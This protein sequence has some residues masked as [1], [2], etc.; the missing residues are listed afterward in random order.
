MSIQV[1]NERTFTLH[2]AHTTYQFEA[3]AFGIVRHL[4]YGSRVED[5]DFSYLVQTRAR[6]FSGNPADAGAD[7]TISWDTLP[8]EYPATGCGD[9]RES[10]IVA[11]HENGSRALDLRYHSYRILDGKPALNGLPAS[12][13]GD[14]TQ[15]LEIT[16]FDRVSKLRVY[17]LYSVFEVRDVITRSVRVEN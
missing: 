16:L 9:Y 8:L 10:C 17:L 2:T 7:R 1:T 15:T 13:A 11:R 4:Y 5:A 14:D 12:L 3:D 6:A